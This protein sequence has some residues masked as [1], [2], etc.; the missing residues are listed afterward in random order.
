[1]L[2]FVDLDTSFAHDRAEL[3]IQASGNDVDETK[4]AL[5]WMRDMIAMPDLRK[6]LET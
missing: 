3:V 2:A 1:M 6:M 5:G 4:R